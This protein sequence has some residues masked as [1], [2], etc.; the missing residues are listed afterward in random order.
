MEGNKVLN[1]IN[2]V[3]RHLNQ[4]FRDD[5]ISIL[6]EL[7]SETVH[8]DVF[9]VKP[10]AKKGRNF[11][12]ALSCGLSILP[13]S[14]PKGFEKFRYAELMM[15]LPPDWNME[16]GEL[17]DLNNW[18]PVVLLTHLTKHP[19]QAETWLGFGHTFAYDLDEPFSS[20]NQF[21]GIILLDSIT[22]PEKFMKIKGWLW[23]KSVNIYIV[24]PLYK[25]E[26]IFKREHGTDA[27]L[28]LFEANHISEIVDLNRKNVCKP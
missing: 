1:N 22:L 25:E 17:R 18:W 6:H 8:S 16:Y 10:D 7:V 4:F 5:E 27:L 13:M 9:V 19:H 11:Y 28:D 15:L 23:Q 14:V 21:V 26:L 20:N 2:R 3:N 12:L 24:I